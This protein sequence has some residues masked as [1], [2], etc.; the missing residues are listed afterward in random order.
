MIASTFAS[1]GTSWLFSYRVRRGD[2]SYADVLDRATIIRDAHGSPVR[3]VGSLAD[4]T[5]LN[6]L[7]AQ[8]VQADRSHRRGARARA[9]DQ[10]ERDPP[11]RTARPHLHRRTADAGQR[12]PARSGLP[13]PRRQRCAGDPAGQR[14]AT[15]DHGHHGGR[16]SR[17][18]L[19]LDFV[20]PAVA[21]H[22]STSTAS[23]TRSSRRSPSV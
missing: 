4:V 22:P 20:S 9:Q 17:P 16:R 2:G 12:I 19:L 1:E 10:R 6:R 7:Q 21:S 15:R 13:E 5:Q 3:L 23:S 8:L 11:S 18:Y 14:R